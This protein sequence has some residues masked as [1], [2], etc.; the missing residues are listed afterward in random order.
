M[1]KGGW[2]LHTLHEVTEQQLRMVAAVIGLSYDRVLSS[3][4][5]SWE[6]RTGAMPRVAFSRLAS[7]AAYIFASMAV[8]ERGPNGRARRAHQ[9]DASLVVDVPSISDFA[10]NELSVPRYIIAALASKAVAFKT[11]HVLARL[12]RARV[13]CAS[14][15]AMVLAHGTFGSGAAA[16]LVHSD[17]GLRL[18]PQGVGARAGPRGEGEASPHSGHRARKGRRRREARGLAFSQRR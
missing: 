5:A 7:I 13:H 4:E 17:R 8:R 1:P 10:V 18:P 12:E 2:W 14:P 11:Q 16:A 15:T 3:D 9:D 6:V